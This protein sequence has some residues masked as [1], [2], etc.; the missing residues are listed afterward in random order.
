MIAFLFSSQILKYNKY[1]KNTKVGQNMSKRFLGI[2]NK[3]VYRVDTVSEGNVKKKIPKKTFFFTYF[4]QL[5]PIR[6]YI[7]YIYFELSTPRSSFNSA[8]C[9]VHLCAPRLLRFYHR[10]C[11]RGPQHTTT[12]TRSQRSIGI[13]TSS[14][15]IIH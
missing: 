12:P 3:A 10:P 9:C 2:S 8:V 15:F 6:I 14:T 4:V 1:F 5:L 11:H 7:R 13:D